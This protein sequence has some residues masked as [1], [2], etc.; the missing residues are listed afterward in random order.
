[1]LIICQNAQRMS[2]SETGLER[3]E[4]YMEG[5]DPVSTGLQRGTF[6]RRR[7]RGGFEGGREEDRAS[8]PPRRRSFPSTLP[9]SHMTGKEGD[10]G[11][12][13]FNWRKIARTDSA[14]SRPIAAIQSCGFGAS[15]TASLVE[16][17]YYSVKNVLNS[18]RRRN[19]G[20]HTRIGGTFH[21]SQ[22]QSQNQ[23][24]TRSSVVSDHAPSLL[25]V[26]AT[27]V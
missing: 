3:G 13:R 8:L 20:E 23:P 26:L 6:A 4:R 2:D 15:Q 12:P 25:T 5:P 22:I 27:F 21:S 16:C 10:V 17:Q 9:T 1:M 24:K 7:T 19:N 11:E 14:K 18:H